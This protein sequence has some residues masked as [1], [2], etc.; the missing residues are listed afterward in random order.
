MLLSAQHR[1]DQ[2]ETLLLRLLRGAGVQG[3]AAMPASRGLGDGHLL[4]PLLDCSRAELEQYAAGRQLHWVEDPSNADT[5]LSRNFLRRQIL[6]A[7]RS[8]WPAAASVLARAAAQQDEAAQLLAELAQQ[9]LAAAQC[10]AQPQWLALPQLEL[11]ALSAL[12]EARQRNALRHWLAG[13][14]RLPDTAHWTGWQ[15][16]R[17]ARADAQPVWRL[18]GG[19][20]QRHA[21]RLYWLSGDWL[22]PVAEQ[23]WPADGV[24]ARNGRVWLAGQGGATA[25]P[26][27]LQIRYR[28]GGE[29]LTL[30]GRGRR[31]LKRLLQ[32]AGLPA[33]VRQRLPLLY[34][35]DQLLAVANL[36]Q[37]SATGWQLDWQP[38]AA[39]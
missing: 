9:D 14:T 32:E 3:L 39:G 18:E 27:G 38:P 25:L 30:P 26:A 10:A 29:Q 31:D 4:R 12:S 17:D 13:V 2:A 7:L 11:S 1:D 15:A 16:L 34:A 24:L 8:H 6:P 19:E 37:L 33:F 22:Q 5:R 21:G 28:Q 20:L 23:D 36:S 35:G